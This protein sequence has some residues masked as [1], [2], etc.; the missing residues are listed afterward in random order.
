MSIPKP[1][2]LFGRV[3]AWLYVPASHRQDEGAEKRVSG[4]SFDG[5]L[6]AEVDLPVARRPVDDVIDFRAESPLGVP[7][8][9]RL[10]L[11]HL[12]E[13]TLCSLFGVANS[14]QLSDLLGNGATRPGQRA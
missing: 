9:S 6:A 4:T 12:V 7:Y 2:D 13:E 1:F 14:D 5:V 10:G 3:V 11:L 8:R